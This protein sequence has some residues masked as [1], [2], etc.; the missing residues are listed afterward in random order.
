MESATRANLYKIRTKCSRVE[1]YKENL[2]E[3]HKKNA[4]RLQQLHTDKIA[5]VSKMT[6]N[7]S[8]ELEEVNRHY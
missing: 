2:V 7:F 4:Q 1:I 6:R 8:H 5:R 3:I